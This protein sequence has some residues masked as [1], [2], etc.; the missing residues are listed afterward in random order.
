MVLFLRSVIW[1]SL[2]FGSYIDT[3]PN[4]GLGATTYERLWEAH[5]SRLFQQFSVPFAVVAA[6]SAV[7]LVRAF[8]R[9]VRH[10]SA[11][12]NMAMA[13]PLFGSVLVISLDWCS[14]YCW[15]TGLMMVAVGVVGP[16]AKREKGDLWAIPWNA[17]WILLAIV[18]A[19]VSWS[20][21][22]D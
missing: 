3:G 17:M 7:F 18:F 19:T 6:I 4:P 20:I 21:Y 8:R 13:W 10:F 1:F 11:L 12:G 9:D 22:G 16:A 14:G 5:G 2:P 15:L